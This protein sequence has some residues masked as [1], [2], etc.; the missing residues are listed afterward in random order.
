MNYIGKINK[1]FSIKVNKEVQG[2]E[3]WLLTWVSY[4]NKYGFISASNKLMFN[5]VEHKFVTCNIIPFFVERYKA[6]DRGRPITFDDFK[7]MILSESFRQFH[8]RYEFE[9]D[10][11]K[12]NCQK[13]VDVDWQIR[14]NLDL[15]TEMGMEQVKNK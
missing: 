3:V 14:N 6:I 2:A 11:V 8:G 9:F 1:L 13:A 10:I 7:E 15:I 4:V 5:D 12:S